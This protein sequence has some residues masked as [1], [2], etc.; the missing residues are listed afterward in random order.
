MSSP[1]PPAPAPKPL[2]LSLL[3]FCDREYARESATVEA[4]AGDASDPSSELLAEPRFLRCAS[5]DGDAALC[6]VAVVPLALRV[7]LSRVSTRRDCCLRLDVLGV[8]DGDSTGAYLEGV[9]AA[10]AWIDAEV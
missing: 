6:G 10:F 3:V 8:W 2:L 7:L 4:A 9:V 1:N 5:G